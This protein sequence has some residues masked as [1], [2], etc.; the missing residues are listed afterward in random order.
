MLRFSGADDCY[1]SSSLRTINPISHH[2]SRPTTHF[3]HKEPINQLPIT[4]Y[5][6]FSFPIASMRSSAS[7]MAAAWVVIPSASALAKISKVRS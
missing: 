4:S 6:A 1:E 3:A 7:L 5:F 2:G